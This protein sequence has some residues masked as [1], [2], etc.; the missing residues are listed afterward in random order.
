MQNRIVKLPSICAKQ[1]PPIWKFEFGFQILKA[2]SRTTNTVRQT[3][4]NLNFK[5]FKFNDPDGLQ[6][7]L[8]IYYNRSDSYQSQIEAQWTKLDFNGT[9]I[10]KESEL[11]NYSVQLSRYQSGS[12]DMF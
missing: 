9:V 10:H 11:Q 7:R 5:S 1:F 4:Q 6:C 12:L 3:V 8:Y 2:L